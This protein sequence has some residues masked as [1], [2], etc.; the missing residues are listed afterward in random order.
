VD[1]VLI[2]AGRVGTAVAILLQRSGHRLVGVASRSLESAQ[3]AADLLG[4]PVF[5][6][7]LMPA[8]DVALLGVP[9]DTLVSVG[10]ELAAS[11]RTEIVCHFAGTV[12]VSPLRDAAEAGMSVAALH[13]V[14]TCPDVE[15]A[16]R[17]L[18]GSAWGV[19]T[20]PEIAEWARD[21]IVDD[22]RGVPV[23]VTEEDRALWHAA[24]VTTSNGA[25]ALMALGEAMLAAMGVLRPAEVLGPLAA[26]TVAT[27]T[28]AG[29]VGG[30]LTGPVVRGEA[31][32]IAAHVHALQTC[33]PELLEPYRLVAR[34]T[35]LAAQRMGRVEPSVAQT[36]L[37]A[38]EA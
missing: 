23:E 6:T 10:A 34:T 22:L 7:S 37:S 8:A 4:A 17:L 20:S 12:G 31:A 25:A 33:A 2:G 15:T 38:L 5:E 14:Q 28:A 21:L 29:D 19:T 27:A 24:A 3:R 16:V 35:L 26:G 9:V 32:T 1:L 11:H 18:P 13:P 36:I 30:T